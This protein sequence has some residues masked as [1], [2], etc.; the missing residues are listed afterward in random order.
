MP[1]GCVVLVEMFGPRVTRV[2]PDGSTE[3]ICRDRGRS[4]R[5][6]RR[7]RRRALPVQQR[8]LL[9]AGRAAAGCCSRV[10]STPTATSAAG[11]SASTCDRHGHRPVHRVRRAAAAGAERPRVRRPR[12]LLV[13]RPRHPRPRRPH[14]DLTGI[15]Y[16]KATAR[17][18]RGRVPGRARRTAS[19][20]RRTD[21]RSTGPRRTPAGCS[22]AVVGP[23]ELARSRRSTRRS[24][25]AGC[26]ACS[27]STRSPSTAT[28]GSASAR[29]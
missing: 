10:R 24:C 26:R 28:A 27:C 4:E 21:R 22:G 15:Y 3:T 12:R 18:Q 19:A 11:S 9:H 5:G 13:H 6:G 29:W 1:D 16:A 2:R 17:D 23:G 25:C 7:P 20:C 8:R 14:G